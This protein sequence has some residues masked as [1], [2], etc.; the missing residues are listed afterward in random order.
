MILWL[1]RSVFKLMM[2][3]GLPRKLKSKNRELSNQKSNLVKIKKIKSLQIIK[4]LDGKV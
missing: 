2:R 3:K 1:P 4:N